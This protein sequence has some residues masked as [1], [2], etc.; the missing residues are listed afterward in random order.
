MKLEFEK[1]CDVCD[2]TGI[3]SKWHGDHYVRTDEPCHHCGGTGL[4]VTED[5]KILIQFLANQKIRDEFDA[6]QLPVT[7][8]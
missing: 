1:P 3:E 4:A 5:G 8:P 7:S 2:A 6:K